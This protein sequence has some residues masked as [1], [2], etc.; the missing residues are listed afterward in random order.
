MANTYKV[1]GQSLPASTS[2]T[3]YTVPAATETVVST[4][5][6]T[7]V[8]GSTATIRIAVLQH[9]FLLTLLVSPLMPP[10]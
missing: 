8:G 4:I 9:Q 7:N 10:M 3:L 2:A 1:L 6:A 5:N